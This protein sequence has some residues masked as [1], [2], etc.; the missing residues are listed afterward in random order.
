MCKSICAMI[1]RREKISPPL[2]RGNYLPGEHNRSWNWSWVKINHLSSFPCTVFHSSYK[3]LL[4][5]KFPH[6]DPHALHLSNR[7]RTAILSL[8]NLQMQLMCSSWTFWVIASV[9]PKK[10]CLLIWRLYT[11]IKYHEIKPVTL[12][13]ILF[14][15][16]L[17]KKFLSLYVILSHFWFVSWRQH[18][19]VNFFSPP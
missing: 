8:A 14:L 18:T 5:Q 10:I 6:S 15:W 13:M 1:L 11:L 17:Y 12:N 9:A 4:H 19:L 7:L 16:V 3:R 2:G